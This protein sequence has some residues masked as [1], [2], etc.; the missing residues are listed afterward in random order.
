MGKGEN[1]CTPSSS[2]VLSS[3]DFCSHNLKQGNSNRRLIRC[4]SLDT[5][6]A[7]GEI[8]ADTGNMDRRRAQLTQQDVRAVEG[9]FAGIPTRMAEDRTGIRPRD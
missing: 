2:D 5:Q 4:A 3:C 1:K 6:I 8:A 7:V 9:I